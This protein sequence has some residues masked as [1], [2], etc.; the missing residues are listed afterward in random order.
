MIQKILKIFIENKAFAR[1]IIEL[2]FEV[3]NN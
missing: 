3:I 2:T 1:A